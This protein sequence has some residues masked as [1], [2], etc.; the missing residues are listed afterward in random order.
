MI[1]HALQAMTPPFNE[2][3]LSWNGRRPKTGHWTFFVRLFQNEWSPWLKMAEWGPDFQRSF[4]EE[5]GFAKSHQ[6]IAKPK[7]GYCTGYEIKVEGDPDSVTVC[8]SDLSQFP[9]IKPILPP[10]QLQNIPTQSQQ[11]LPH[12]RAKDLCSPTSTSMALHFLQCPIDPILFATKVHDHTFDIY[13]NWML[14]TAA[15]SEF[16]RPKY[17][18][19]VARLPDF[20]ALHTQLQ[21]GLPVVVSIKGPLPGAPLA[22]ANGHLILVTGYDQDRVYCMDPGFHANEQTLTS[23]ALDDF[24]EAW[25]TRRKNLAYLFEKV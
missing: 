13:G 5:N 21:K 14:N 25:T 12:S 17:R 10:V 19:Y 15:A 6:D 24:L 18:T 8:L 2:L 22:Y 4:A 23:Y 3:I 1:Y 16:L 9:I 11:I 7:N 20:A